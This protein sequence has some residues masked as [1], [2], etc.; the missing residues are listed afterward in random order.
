MRSDRCVLRR[1]AA[2]PSPSSGFQRRRTGIATQLACYRF[3]RMTAC[4]I[5]SARGAA[6]QLQAGKLLSGGE[7]QATHFGRPRHGAK[8]QGIPTA[9]YVCPPAALVRKSC[10]KVAG[11][12]GRGPFLCLALPETF[13]PSPKTQGLCLVRKP[14]PACVSQACAV[15][16]VNRCCMGRSET[17]APHL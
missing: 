7:H 16:S 17:C 3:V 14:D 5:L 10:A 15:T 4:R 12:D 8:S 9:N 11:R 13:G 2:I 6:H 1:T